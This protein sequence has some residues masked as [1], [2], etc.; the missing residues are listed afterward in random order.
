MKIN[1]NSNCVGCGMCQS[2]AED[3]FKVA[4]IPAHV[5]KQP[6]T[7]E[8]EKLCAEAIDKCPVGA[9]YD[10]EAMKAAA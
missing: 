4:G 6:A 7:P 10:E 2:V 9:I 5:I 8:E 3:F 1:I